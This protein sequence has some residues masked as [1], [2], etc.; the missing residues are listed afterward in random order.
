LRDACVE[1]D[2]GRVDKVMEKLE[3]F[4]YENGEELIA[5]LHRQ[6]DDMSFSLI[7][8]GKWPVI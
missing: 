3:S 2:I 8:D 5:W 1:Y 7:S 4:E 6:V